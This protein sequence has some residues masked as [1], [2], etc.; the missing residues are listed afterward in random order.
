MVADFRNSNRSASI[1]GPLSDAPVE[2][3]HA[4]APGSK[5]G[6]S[7]GSPSR[8]I[9]Q[10][11]SATGRAEPGPAGS[12]MQ[13]FP[14]QRGEG[15]DNVR[16]KYGENSPF[17]PLQPNLKASPLR[18]KHPATLIDRDRLSRGLNT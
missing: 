15:A 1:R 17:R 14:D 7:V 12:G 2:E 16:R 8:L 6:Y 9:D 4:Q 3:I 18:Q 10:V 13:D 5:V 11:C